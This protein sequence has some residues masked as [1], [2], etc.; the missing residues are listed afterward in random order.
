MIKLLSFGN[1]KTA[2]L[3]AFSA[4][5]FG[6]YAHAQSDAKPVTI[7]AG[8]QVKQLNLKGRKA[9]SGL[10]RITP[11]KE[12]SL[13]KVKDVPELLG[14]PGMSSRSG[15]G[16]LRRVNRHKFKPRVL[17]IQKQQSRSD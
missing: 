8:G 5:V 15:R 16:V 4:F 11:L 1:I 17:R 6:A 9:L 14:G 3:I 7:I 2:L 13:E 10:P 12:V